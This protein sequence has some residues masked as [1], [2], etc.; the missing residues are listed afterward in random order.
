MD[1]GSVTSS[2]GA[3][4]KDELALQV[5]TSLMRKTRELTA[6]TVATLIDSVPTTSVSSNPPHLGTQ[7]DTHA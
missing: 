7:I 6:Q 1:I 5:Q 4:S 3:Q 2:G